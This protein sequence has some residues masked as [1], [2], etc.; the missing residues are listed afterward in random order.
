MSIANPSLKRTTITIATLHNAVAISPLVQ[1]GL[2]YCFWYQYVSLAA[3]NLIITYSTFKK[4]ITMIT[5]FWAHKIYVFGRITTFITELFFINFVHNVWA[6]AIVN[7]YLVVDIFHISWTIN[8]I[9]FQLI[10]NSIASLWTFIFNYHHVRVTSITFFGTRKLWIWITD[11]WLFMNEFICEIWLVLISL[12]IGP[13][14]CSLLSKASRSNWS[15]T[16]NLI[17]LKILW[18]I[19]KFL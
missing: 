13:S 9:I 1:I 15:L 12:W 4:T 17:I 6:Y 5:I 3:F 19:S 14:S 2:D 7:N 10:L 8:L 11:L 18:V 16:V